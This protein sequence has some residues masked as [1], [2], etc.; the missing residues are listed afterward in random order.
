MATLPRCGIGLKHTER[1][2]IGIHEVGVP[3]HTG[4][5][6]LRQCDRSAERL[7]ALSLGVNVR[8]FHRAHECIGAALQWRRLRRPLEQTT[9]NTVRLD[10]PVRYGHILVPGE[11]PAK[12][13]LIEAGCSFRLTRMDLEV[14]D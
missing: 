5:G 12:K 2:A 10:S 3:A 13:L 1:I 14:C 8:H 11:T 6:E 7:Y 9:M 4:N